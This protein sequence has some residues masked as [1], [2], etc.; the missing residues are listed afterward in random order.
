MSMVHTLRRWSFVRRMNGRLLPASRLAVALACLCV[1]GPAW[2]QGPH[3]HYQH[4]AQMSPGAIGSWQLRRG[5]PLTGYF[6]PVE[7][8]APPGALV[9]LAVNGQFDELRPAPRV[10]GMLIA[11]VYRLRVA[12]IPQLEGAEVFPTIE[13]IDRLYPPVGQVHR[14][15][16]VVELTQEDLELAVSGRFV[17]RVIYLEDPQRA[18]AT[19]EDDG[20]LQRWFDC[21]AGEDPLRIADTL[22][23]PVAILRMGARWPEDPT[24]P[25]PDFLYGCPPWIAVPDRREVAQPPAPVPPKQDNDQAGI[26]FDAPARLTAGGTIRR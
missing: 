8:K 10:A 19:P 12:N 15:P 16:I 7:I 13:V 25:G 23:R 11:P 2:G 3:D 5:G 9:S 6:Q 24:N 4:H 21:G 1:A 14:F 26:L 17:T 22:G 18:A 20:T